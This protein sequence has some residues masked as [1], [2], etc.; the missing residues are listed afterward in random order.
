MISMLVWTVA[1]LQF[2]EAYFVTKQKITNGTSIATPSD[3]SRGL[4][5]DD[6]VKDRNNQVP[7]VNVTN[8]YMKPAKAK[9]ASIKIEEYE[10]V[11]CKPKIQDMNRVGGISQIICD[12]NQV[13]QDLLLRCSVIYEKTVLSDNTEILVG[14]G[15]E[16][17]FRKRYQ[18]RKLAVN[19]PDDYLYDCKYSK[20]KNIK[21]TVVLQ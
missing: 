19:L 2:S 6:I 16:L 11:P 21:K 8:D 13:N 4:I 7:K 3:D 5:A 1:A 12:S 15:C 17:R 14:V 20:S 10:L 18:N 9:W